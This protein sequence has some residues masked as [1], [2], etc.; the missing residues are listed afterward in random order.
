MLFGRDN[1]TGKG[2]VDVCVAI[3]CYFI[4]NSLE[5]VLLYIEIAFMT[6]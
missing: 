2:R 5:S 4:S 1:A 3:L 6:L